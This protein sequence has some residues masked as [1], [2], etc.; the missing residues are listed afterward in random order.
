MML[1]A[2]NKDDVRCIRLFLYN[3]ALSMTRHKNKVLFFQIL[4]FYDT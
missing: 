2:K 3:F 1:L 4:L